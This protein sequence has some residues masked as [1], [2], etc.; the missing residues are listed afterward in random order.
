MLVVGAYLY[1]RPL[2]PPVK[3]NVVK[4]IP[5]SLGQDD[6][7]DV[8][9][10]AKSLEDAKPAR[11]SFEMENQTSENYRL[12]LQ[13]DVQ[14]SLSQNLKKPSNYRGMFGCD[15]HYS[16]NKLRE[17]DCGNEVYARAVQLALEATG[18]DELSSPLTSDYVLEV[19]L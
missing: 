6:V 17:L 18:D 12:L 15:L 3:T 5:L 4:T 7:Y 19:K 14:K 13:R 11:E 8:A 1:Q 10:Q 9:S 2:Q 16:G